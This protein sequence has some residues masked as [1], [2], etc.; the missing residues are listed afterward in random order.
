MCMARRWLMP[1]PCLTKHLWRQV[2]SANDRNLLFGSR[3]ESL[4]PASIS[5]LRASC[6]QLDSESDKEKQPPFVTLAG[7]YPIRWSCVNFSQSRQKALGSRLL[8]LAFALQIFQRFSVA[9][10]SSS[11]AQLLDDG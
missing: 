6:Q 9:S 2:F 1:R 5:R 10:R 11:D 7:D 4:K 3:R 8:I